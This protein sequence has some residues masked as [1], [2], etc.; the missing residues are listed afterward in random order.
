[1]PSSPTCYTETVRTRVLGKTGITCSEVALGTWGLSGDGYGPVAF[2][3]QD[4]I[5]ERA[6]ALGISLVETSDVYAGGEM[7]S[8][9]GR[10]LHGDSS[11]IIATKIG[12]CRVSSP[13]RKRFDPEWLTQS[14]AGSRRRLRRETLDVVLLHNPSLSTLERGDACE[15]LIDR[16]RAGEIR[17]WGVSAGSGEVASAA[18]DAGAMVVQ[19][20]FNVLWVSDYRH[21]EARLRESG[22]GFLARSVLAHGLLCGYWSQD[23]AFDVG[24]HRRERW[25]VDELRQ[26]LR[27]LDAL[28]PNLTGGLS[29][30][31]AVALRW[32]LSHPT[33][34]SAVL[35]PR[36]AL[37]LDQLVRDA[38]SP[39]DA[40]SETAL[41]AL[42]ARLQDAGARS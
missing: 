15:W 33:V 16:V 31:R 8:R 35:G 4:R 11:M 24:D 12:T 13:P 21:V 41:R 9:L 20:A 28:R 29:S 39:I 42:E 22:T 37:Q 19:L 14:V 18:L 6:R 5:I 40:L 23:R 26:R 2:D 38:S 34:S 25:T 1:M 27:H 32:V 3:E 36:S 30:L 10:T 17:A 7:E